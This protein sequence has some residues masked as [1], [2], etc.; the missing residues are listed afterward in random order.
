MSALL[1]AGVLLVFVIGALALFARG[2]AGEPMSTSP[3]KL[4]VTDNAELED[5]TRRAI[6]RM[7]L[8]VE[9]M[10]PLESDGFGFLAIDSA[11]ITGR[12]VYVRTIS[13]TS[14]ERAHVSDV[15]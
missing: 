14:G 15:Q 12:R 3:Q 5:L 1:L 4:V 6:S 8:R 10:D 13:R 7:G 9:R 11:P 2:G